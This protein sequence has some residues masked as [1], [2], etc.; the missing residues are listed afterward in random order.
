MFSHSG[1]GI[2][3]VQTSRWCWHFDCNTLKWHERQS[4]LQNYWRHLQPHYAFNVWLCGDR[5]TGNVYVIDSDIETEAG[6]PLVA[7]MDGVV[8]VFPQKTR[9]GRIDINC[10]HGVGIVT[11][12]TPI[13]TDPTLHISYSNNGGV[14]WSDPTKRPLGQMGKPLGITSVRN[15]GIVR[16]QGFRVRLTVSD[17]VYFAIMSGNV[18]AA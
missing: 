14:D 2:V 9:I 16:G 8:D 1:R 15:C 7:Q 3:S 6:E 17:P 5:E 10:T 4:Y 18:E 12:T 11:G 13:Q